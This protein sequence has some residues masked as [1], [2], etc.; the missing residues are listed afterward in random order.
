MVKYKKLTIFQNLKRKNTLNN[1]IR[2]IRDYYTSVNH[3]GF[4]EIE[5]QENKTSLSCRTQI[6]MIINNVHK[7]VIDAGQNPVMIWTPPPIVGGYVMNIDIIVNVFD[8]NRYQISLAKLQDVIQ[9]SFASYHD[10]TILSII[11]TINPFYYFG[12]SIKWIVSLP[13]SLLIDIGFSRS[14]VEDSNVVKIIKAV[15]ELIGWLS[16]LLII[17][18]ILGWLDKLKILVP[19]IFSK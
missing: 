14:K 19:N 4:I 17:L 1:F 2:L 7:Y 18:Q 12:Y 10:T 16:S 11:N 15:G 6:N 9:R 13:F 8:L 3:V 5:T